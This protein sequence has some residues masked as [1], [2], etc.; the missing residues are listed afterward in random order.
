MSDIFLK[1]GSGDNECILTL[2]FFKRISNKSELILS[3]VRDK[4]SGI[5]STDESVK[6]NVQGQLKF[7]NEISLFIENIKLIC[8][9]YDL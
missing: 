1:R 7:L 3:H 4:I 8:N 5:N 9:K 2:C 6:I